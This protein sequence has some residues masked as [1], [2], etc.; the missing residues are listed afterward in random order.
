[1]GGCINCPF[2]RIWAKLQAVCLLCRVH[3]VLYLRDLWF[4]LCD[5][6]AWKMLFVSTDVAFCCTLVTQPKL[7]GAAILTVHACQKMSWWDISKK[8]PQNTHLQRGSWT[9]PQAACEDSSSWCWV[10]VR[11]EASPPELAAPESHCSSHPVRGGNTKEAG[12]LWPYNMYESRSTEHRH[13]AH[14]LHQLFGFA[15]LLGDRRE[16]VVAHEQNFEGEAEQVFRQN[17]QEIS[18]VEKHKTL[19]YI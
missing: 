15:D 4:I 2:N 16:L 8:N 12:W 10:L 6:A 14:Q 5:I 19:T 3:S 13:T 7:T 9:D 18:A 17:W 1:M 11:L